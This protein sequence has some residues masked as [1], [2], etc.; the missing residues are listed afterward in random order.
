M[1]WEYATL[2]WNARKGLLGRKPDV[3]ALTD[4]LNKYGEDGWELVSATDTSM[5]GGVRR[6]V[7]LVFKRPVP[8]E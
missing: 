5:E 3:Q 8:S 1:K 7:L 6:N 2:L 4:N